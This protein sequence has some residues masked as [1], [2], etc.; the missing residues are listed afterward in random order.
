MN[1]ISNL[2]DVLASADLPKK[3][4][5]Y[6]DK[7]YQSLKNEELLKQKNIKNRILKKAKKNKPLSQTEKKFN[8]LCG[9]VRYKVERTFGGIKRWFNSGI[10]R[11]KGIS[12]MHTQNLME[13]IC[14]NLYRSPRIVKLN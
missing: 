1:E 10:A 3:V 13:G 2:E 6:A 5:L 9:K 11:Y 8:K 14:Y 12:K 4:T 7:G